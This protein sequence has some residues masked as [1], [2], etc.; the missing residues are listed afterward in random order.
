[1]KPREFHIWHFPEEKIRILFKNHR[2]FIE[3]TMNF[4]GSQKAL[5][6][7][8]D[9]SPGLLVN[10]K[11]HP[12]YIPL[13]SVKKIVKKLNLNWFELEKTILAYK[14][15]NTSLPIRNPIL[16]IKETP[17]LF[18]IITHLICD[19]CVN[20]N[21]VP[22]YINSNK[23][24]LDN[25]ASLLKKTFGGINI[26]I[27][28]LQGKCYQYVFQKIIIE[29]ITNFYDVRFDSMKAYFPK[30][31]F[32]LPKNFAYSVIRAIVDDEGCVRDRGIVIS[33]KNKRLIFQIRKIIIS[34]FRQDSVN[35]PYRRKDT[36]CWDVIIKPS[37][38]KKFGD[39][40]NLIHLE[41]REYLERIIKKRDSISLNKKDSWNL[42]IRL[43]ELLNQKEGTQVKELANRLPIDCG[44][45]NVNL[46]KLYKRRFVKKIKFGYGNKW[47]LTEKGLDFLKRWSISDKIEISKIKWHKV[48][49]LPNN[50]F[51]VLLTTYGRKRLF[52]M[53]RR[54]LRNQDKIA[55]YLQVHRNTV[56]NWE[57]GKTKIPSIKLN[58]IL[59]LLYKKGFDISNDIITNI[60][61]ISSLNGRY[62][63]YGGYK[64]GTDI[65]CTI[66]A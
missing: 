1:M 36:N 65:S 11:R 41:K 2:K 37:A 13:S 12:L 64:N 55:N 16:P 3:N 53:L 20:K 56:S 47:F 26:T 30:E 15:V 50:N 40:I 66:T 18:G 21:G 57:I 8:L 32:H 45:V 10:W 17:K 43:L 54:I 49:K 9:I 7:F 27:S 35:F 6:N 14:G 28:K 62:K 25:F 51:R 58:D 60:N 39:K 31:I 29:L 22:M 38:L 44:N 33:M 19:G 48:F 23:N 24:L 5:A 61:E 63:I 59:N 52:W 46:N 42:K 34:V 4:F